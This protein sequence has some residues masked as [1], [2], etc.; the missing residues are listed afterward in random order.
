[1]S[2]AIMKDIIKK[3]KQIRAKF[4]KIL[5]DSGNEDWKD[6]QRVDEQNDNDR[7]EHYNLQ[8]RE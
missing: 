6:Q 8:E 5:D 3:R 2:I 1:M 4:K 7:F